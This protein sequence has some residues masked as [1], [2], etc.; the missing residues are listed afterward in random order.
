MMDKKEFIRSEAARILTQYDNVESA[1]KS[2]WQF[3]DEQVAMFQ[4]LSE[5]EKASIRL[6]YM[7]S[8]HPEIFSN[9]IIVDPE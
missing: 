4:S 3:T 2:G 5:D 6:G 9:S 1:V 8:L 7:V